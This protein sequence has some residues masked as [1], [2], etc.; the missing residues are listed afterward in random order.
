MCRGPTQYP[1][2]TAYFHDN[3]Y[4]NPVMMPFPFPSLAP[5]TARPPPAC[6]APTPAPY[7]IK[8]ALARGDYRSPGGRFHMSSSASDP[9]VTGRGMSHIPMEENHPQA[10]DQENALPSF[11]TNPTTIQS[12]LHNTNASRA[13]LRNPRPNWLT[14]PY[15]RIR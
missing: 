2:T 13:N 7:R 3:T 12:P 4:Q 10:C 6:E 11:P 8:T 1:T 5:T 15:L 14:S 9:A